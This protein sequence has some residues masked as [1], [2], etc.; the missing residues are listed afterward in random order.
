MKV[1]QN[2]ENW[3]EQEKLKKLKEY[4]KDDIDK[5][6]DLFVELSNE[7]KMIILTQ[8]LI[9]I[10]NFIL[11]KID[12]E[13]RG[14]IIGTLG[15]LYYNLGRFKEAE[16]CY[17]DA[18]KLYVELAKKD[19]NYLKYVAG[20][21]N[22]LGNLY[23]AVGRP[24]DAEKSFREA[25]II[26]Q[27]IKDEEG[28]ITTL[29]SLGLLYSNMAEYEK[30]RDYYERALLNRMKKFNNSIH[31][32]YSLGTI[33]NNLGA[34]YNGL[35]EKD[36]AEESYKKAIEIYK[37]LLEKEERVEDMLCGAMSNLASLYIDLEKLNDAEK[38]LNEIRKYESLLPPDLKV[39]I[40]FNNAKLLEKRGDKNAAEEYLK[41]GSMAFV[42][43]V[44]YGINTINF[45]YCFEKVE[46]IGEGK[47]RGDAKLM[48][49]AML[50][51][52]FG[53]E[54]DK[55]LKEVECSHRGRAILDALKG[56]FK[57]EVRDEVDLAAYIIA[58]EIKRRSG[59]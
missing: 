59:F 33:L 45:V 51:S 18:L 28:V 23:Y 57:L 1:K 30:A 41:A 24:I 56:N 19:E 35:N 12:D 8:E 55:E 54:K 50:K 31:D 49:R 39:K 37:Q 48:R 42:L 13:R 38:L 10:G 25:L 44:T 16:K 2:E 20:V 29:S 32:M 17:E 52:Y 47:I 26:R 34:V 58:T 3:R 36:K 40:V 5:A 43:F 53:L 14:R 22:N 15:N 46:E 9:E 7:A 6:I 11:T 4:L 27:D 21:L